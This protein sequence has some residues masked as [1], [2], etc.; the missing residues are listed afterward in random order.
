MTALIDQNEG[1]AR[2]ANVLSSSIRMHN[3]TL[4]LPI[5]SDYKGAAGSRHSLVVYDEICGFESEKAR[6]LYE[7]LTPPPTE[8]SAWILIVTY[9]GFLG[10]SDLLESIYQ[11]GLAGKRVDN[12]LE[13]YESHELFM[14]WSHTPRQ[15]LQDEKY[16]EQQRKILRPANFS[17]LH[18]NE[19]VSSESRFIDPELWSQNVNPALRQ[20]TTGSLFIGI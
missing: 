6:R 9:A 2:E 1:L 13:C 16:Y 5:A 11:R 8:S 19:W 4:I 3:G 7:E 15:R 18:R 17:R 14:F 12:E 10:E 20:D